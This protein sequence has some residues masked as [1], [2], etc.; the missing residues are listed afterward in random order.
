MKIAEYIKE[1]RGEMTHVNWP[2]RRQSIVYT[3]LVIVI[4]V[5]IGIL[6]G[7]FDLGFTKGLQSII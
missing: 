2:T 3:I 1:T 4:A 7:A 6:L 5:A